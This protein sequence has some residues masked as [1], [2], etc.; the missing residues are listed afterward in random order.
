MCRDLSERGSEKGRPL[1]I[2]QLRSAAAFLTVLPVGYPEGA[3]GQRLGRAFWPLI[4]G[5]V[6]GAAGLIFF[7]SSAVAG[8]WLAAVAAVGTLAILTRGLHLD[9]LAD[10]FDGLWGGQTPERRLEIMRDHATGAFGVIALVLVLAGEIVALAQLP[11]SRGTA[12]L[13]T[14]GLLSRWAMLGA[15]ALLPYARA[16]GLG[17][18]AQG[19][20]KW[21]DLS[22]GTVSAALSLMLDWRRALLAAGLAVFAAAAVNGLAARKIGGATGDVY[23]AT[24]VLGELGALI[25]FV[26]HR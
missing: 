23:G 2:N 8:R 7:A 14:A 12:A 17:L 13:V 24:A 6:G 16:S 11:A 18:A 5:M 25:A 9:G 3:T 19:P 22:L 26:V 1:M 15:A 21:L 4:G 10:T 20:G